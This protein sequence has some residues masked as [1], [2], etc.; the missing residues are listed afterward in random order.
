M[1]PLHLLVAPAAKAQTYDTSAATVTCDTFIGTVKIKPPLGAIPAATTLKVKG[2]L[3]GC[4]A[5]GATPASPSLSVLSGKVSGTLSN[6]SGSCLALAGSNPFSGN[7]VVKWKVASGQKLDASSTTLTPG[8]ING[9]VLVPGGAFGGAAYVQFAFG[10]TLQSGSAFT[11][12]TP[13]GVFAT[14]E[15][16]GNLLGQCNGA[17]VKLIHIG[18]GTSTL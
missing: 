15:D 3:S 10:G 7:L 8:T 17:G 4:F 13:S 2:T 18:I 12:A 1:I 11:G 16:V 5:S 14:A 9:G 6:P